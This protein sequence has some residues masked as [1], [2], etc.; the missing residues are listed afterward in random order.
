MSII[1]HRLV[2]SKESFKEHRNSRC[3]DLRQR[4]QGR[5]PPSRQNLLEVCFE[6]SQGEPYT[7]R[8]HISALTAK[9]LQ[10]C[11]GGHAQGVTLCM[12]LG[13]LWRAILWGVPDRWHSA[14]KLSKRVTMEASGSGLWRSHICMTRVGS[15]RSLG[16]SNS[17]LYEPRAG[18]TATG[19]WWQEPPLGREIH[20]SF[21]VSLV[22]SSDRVQHHALGQRRNIYRTPVQIPQ[23]KQ[24]RVTLELRSSKLITGILSLT[25][26]FT[27]FPPTPVSL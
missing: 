4:D 3:K 12:P 10:V 21:S 6:G 20:F 9:P 14:P 19:V 15:W 23:N 11:I 22:P 16:L 18:E 2:R 8:C 17:I 13:V 7:G 27:L 24:W 1:E 26:L 5:C 25:W